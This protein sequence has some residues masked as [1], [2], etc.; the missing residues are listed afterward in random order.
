MRVLRKTSLARIRVHP[1]LTNPRKH[2]AQL[3]NAAKQDN[4]ALVLLP[5]TPLGSYAP[6]HASCPA[7]QQWIRPATGL[8]SQEAAWIQ[9]R[10]PVVL[11]AFTSYLSRL[12]ITDLNVTALRKAMQKNQNAGVPVIGMAISGGGWA[13]SLTGTGALR[14]FDA[15]F[16]NAID[17]RTGGIL[18]S[19]S[20]LSGLSGGAWPPMSL[21]TYNF[22]TINDMVANWHTDIDRLFDPP[23]NTIYAANSTVIFTDVYAK[24]KAG[25]AVSVSDYLGIGFGYEFLPPPQAGINVTLSGVRNLSNFQNHSMPMP[26]FQAARLTDDDVKFYGMK[27]PY[28]NSSLFEMTPFEFGSWTGS[29]GSATGFTPMEYM[30]TKLH[31]GK[32]TN[33]STCVI[34]YDR[35]SNI[36][37]LAASAVNAWYIEALS[38]GT[39]AQF[40]KKRSL[41]VPP[42]GSVQSLQKR[43]GFPLATINY[44]FEAYQQYFNLTKVQAVSPSVPNPFAG[45]PGANG[46]EPATLT[47][48]D[49]SEGGQAI[50]FWPM[51]QPARNL[52]FIIS[53]DNDE[54][55]TPNGWNNGTNIYNTFIQARRHGLPF[56][57]IPPPATFIKRNYTQKPVFFGCNPQ[58]TT[59]RNLDSPIVLEMTNAPYSAYT[60]YTWFKTA[61]T[62]VEMH[63]I[64]VN[65]WD[66]VT[67]GNSTLESDWVACIGCAAVD[68]TLSKL[69]IARPEQC[70]RC[71]QKYCWDGTYE[72]EADI[73]VVD[74]ALALH[75]DV[76]YAEWNATHPFT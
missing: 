39:L 51:L 59:T 62:P 17:Q 11:D 72:D 75:P 25:F 43:A 47:L 52:D 58:Y 71:L 12:N 9:G 27:V 22:P 50:P 48:A 74:P 31:D 23:N 60:N 67:Q 4:D 10:K 57:E 24:Y 21:A 70:E 40:S 6:V 73:P 16:P 65:S 14:A 56:P 66:L 3:P 26:I 18:Q 53:W 28:A 44:L 2:L 37:G 76:S 38:N 13:S 5:A 29:D 68:R 35:G 19:L 34:G 1:R 8:S 54:D 7:N 32:V 63:E 49:G 45:M 15:R 46:P 61:F 33:S 20:Y 36:L 64:L 69:D 42:P 30:G 41:Q 55:S